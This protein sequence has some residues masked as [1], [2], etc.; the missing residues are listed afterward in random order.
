MKVRLIILIFLAV[1]LLIIFAFYPDSSLCYIVQWTY[2]AW[3]I[4]CVISL[5]YITFKENQKLKITPI[6]YN[7]IYRVIKS[8]AF[9]YITLKLGIKNGHYPTRKIL[10]IDRETNEIVFSSEGMTNG[11]PLKEYGDYIIDTGNHYR[12]QIN[13]LNNKVKKLVIRKK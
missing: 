8:D 3:V 2:I 7:I 5:K 9:G 10:W 11:F 1:A 6:L 13:F 4:Y 12:K